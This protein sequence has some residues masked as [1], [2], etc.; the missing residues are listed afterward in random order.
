MATGQLMVRRFSLELVDYSGRDI[1]S[2]SDSIGKALHLWE[3]FGRMSDGSTC[4]TKAED[5][6][7]C[8]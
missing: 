6:R 3:V 5:I 1:S 7:K 8:I 2:I 4:N